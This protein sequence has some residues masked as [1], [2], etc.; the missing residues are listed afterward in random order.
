MPLSVVSFMA[1]FPAKEVTP[2][3]ERQMKEWL[4]NRT[5]QCD[6]EL[7]TAKL[8]RTRLVPFHRQFIRCT[9][10]SHTRSVPGFRWSG[11][12]C[13]WRPLSQREGQRGWS[14]LKCTMVRIQLRTLLPAVLLILHLSMTQKLEVCKWTNSNQIQTTRKMYTLGLMTS[15][16]F[17]QEVFHPISVTRSGWRVRAFACFV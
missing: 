7:Y 2:E 17:L 15:L 12:R 8:R 10:S 14:Q 16:K 1:P 6:R 4:E 3:T 13:I 5:G 11:R 9:P